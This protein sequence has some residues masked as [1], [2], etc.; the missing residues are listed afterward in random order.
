M[1]FRR[2]LSGPGGRG[3]LVVGLVAATLRILNRRAGEPKALLV[4]KLEP[5]QSFVITHFPQPGKKSKRH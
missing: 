2:A 4:E 1:G 3:W 5:G